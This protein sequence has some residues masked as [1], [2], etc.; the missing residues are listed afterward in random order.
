MRVNKL[1][2]NNVLVLHNGRIDC[3]TDIYYN[4]T[5]IILFDFLHKIEG[6]DPCLTIVTGRSLLL[7]KDALDFALDR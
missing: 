5:S 4:C 6:V 3:N 7:N 1:Y 2:Y